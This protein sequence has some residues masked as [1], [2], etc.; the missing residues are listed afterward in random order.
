MNRHFHHTA[1]IKQVTRRTGD[2]SL[3]LEL[4]QGRVSRFFHKKTKAKQKSK[5]YVDG[6]RLS[7]DNIT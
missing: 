1:K 5:E 3:M 6:L 2:M 4:S 7:G